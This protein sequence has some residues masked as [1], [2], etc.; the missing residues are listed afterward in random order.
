MLARAF[1]RYQ[2]ITGETRQ[3]IADRLGWGDTMFDVVTGTSGGIPTPTLG[4]PRVNLLP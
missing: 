1:S 3:E 2:Q 4:T